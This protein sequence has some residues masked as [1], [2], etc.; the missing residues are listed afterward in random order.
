MRLWSWGRRVRSRRA[1]EAAR[2]PTSDCVAD[3]QRD[4]CLPEVKSVE[5][6]K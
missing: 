5:S 3:R 1:R 6:R 4:A 2:R